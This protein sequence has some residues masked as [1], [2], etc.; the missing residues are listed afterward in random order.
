MIMHHMLKEYVNIIFSVILNGYQ[1]NFLLLF[2]M[3]L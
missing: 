3:L 1:L 2:K